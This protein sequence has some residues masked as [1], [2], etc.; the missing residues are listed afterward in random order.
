MPP[1]Q[2]PAQVPPQMPSGVDT[3]HAPKVLL[4][5]VLVAILILLAFGAYMLRDT[6]VAEDDQAALKTE[7]IRDGVSL[8]EKDLET[9]DLTNLDKELDSINA[10]LNASAQ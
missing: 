2:T 9:A 8:I 1:Q 4:I 6:W 5:V 7:Q 10:E 3:P